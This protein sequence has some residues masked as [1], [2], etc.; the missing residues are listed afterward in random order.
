MR[1]MGWQVT[2]HST[3]L[4]NEILRLPAGFVARKSSPSP[5]SE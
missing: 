2:L 1:T 3:A 5:E 4:Q